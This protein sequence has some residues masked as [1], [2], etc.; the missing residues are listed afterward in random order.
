VE[1]AGHCLDPGV[2]DGYQRLGQVGVSEADSFI[3]G[4]RRSLVA[5]VSDVATAMLEVG[6]H[7]DDADSLAEARQLLSSR[8]SVLGEINAALCE[9]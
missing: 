9:N 2:G 6:S 7:G 8:F 5:S 3:H 1:V 4:A